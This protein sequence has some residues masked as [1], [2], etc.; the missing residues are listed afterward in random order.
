MVLFRSFLFIIVVAGL[1]GCAGS[2]YRLKQMQAEELKTVSDGDLCFAVS[3]PDRTALMDQE[4]TRRGLDC[5]AARK[6]YAAQSSQPQATAPHR[7]GSKQA[8]SGEWKKPYY[9][10]NIVDEFDN[11]P[12]AAAQ[13]YQTEQAVQFSI[14]SIRVDGSNA[15]LSYMAEPTWV[16]KEAQQFKGFDQV[17]GMSM[18][19][20]IYEVV[21][22]MPINELDADSRTQKEVTLKAKLVKYSGNSIILACRK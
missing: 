4:V 9:N 13:K 17:M 6:S 1:S 11:D 19:R 20:N 5:S 12:V 16:G 21:C 10:E 18:Q 22:V 7:S 15:I 14:K 8:S 3:R 2:P